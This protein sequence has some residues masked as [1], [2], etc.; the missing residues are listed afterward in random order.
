MPLSVMKIFSLP[1]LLIFST[2]YFMLCAERNCPFLI[3]ICLLVLA[4]ATN[5]SVCLQRNAGI[6]KTSTYLDASFA[7]DGVWISVNIGILSSSLTFFNIFSAISS[8]MPL[9]ESNRVL[10]A[11]LNEPLK[12][13][14]IFNL[15]LILLISFAIL[16]VSSSDS[17]TQGP[18]TK[19][20]LSLSM[21]LI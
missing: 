7:S 8:P 11:F 17:I 3:F 12:M 18:A 6:C 9:N 14:G 16:N 13:N 19:K 15:S 10:F 1:C 21:F 20:K 4:A 2:A 5:K